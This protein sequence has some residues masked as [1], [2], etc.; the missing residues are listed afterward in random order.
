MYPLI[1]YEGKIFHL[2]L[3]RFPY[4]LAVRLKWVHVFLT[5][6]RGVRQTESSLFL[7]VKPR[8]TRVISKVLDELSHLS[9]LV[10]CMS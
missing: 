2:D 1:R 9:E 3:F 10:A 6:I 5:R 7:S 4:I 8:L